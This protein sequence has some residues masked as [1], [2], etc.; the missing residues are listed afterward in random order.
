MATTVDSGA[1]RVADK[2]YYSTTL[3][4][5][6]RVVVPSSSFTFLN[7]IQTKLQEKLTIS[8]LAL[9]LADKYFLFK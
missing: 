7:L 3:F 4:L 5:H 9:W 8:D 6:Q 1:T 2:Q